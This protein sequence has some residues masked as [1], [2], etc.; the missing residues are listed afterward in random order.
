M[1]FSK[2]TNG[3]SSAIFAQLEQRK[4]EQLAKG[5]QIINF[6]IGT[7]D[8]PPAPHIMKVLQ[9]EAAKPENYIYAIRDLPELTETVQNWYQR[10]F[11]VHLETDEI[12]AMNG[13]QDGLSH[14]SLAITN[15]GDLVLTPDPCYPI[16]STGPQLA[17]AELYPIS[18][19]KANNY[20]ID[21]DQIPASVAQKAKLMIV[22][23]PNNPVTATAPYDFYEKLVWFAKKY[24]II[25]LHDNAYCEL[26]YDGKK[27][28]SFLAV[29]GAKDV[30]IEFNSLSKTYNM[31]G[32]RI[33]FA[34]GNRKIIERFR[35]L[36]SHLDYGIF[37]PIQKAAIA[38]LNGS[39]EC[40][41]QT[42]RAYEIR[43]N[44]IADGF[45]EIGWKINKP[46]GTMFI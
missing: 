27:G 8:L 41:V 6:S 16:F 7:P 21:L 25:V 45:G 17:E 12:L 40:V 9:E 39:Q 26:V 36:K 18:L 24:D 5:R 3:L 43:R 28:G 22:S 42:V 2:R 46:Q 4:Q 10:R 32:C 11:G 31:P 33:S 34:L 35:T 20:V 23:Y 38:A 37:L 44:L 13:S 30:G 1:E 29:P 15:P 14:I 19:L